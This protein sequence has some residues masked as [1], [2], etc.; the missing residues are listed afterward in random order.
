MRKSAFKSLQFGLKIAA[1]ATIFIA[2]EAAAP[3]PACP[4]DPVPTVSSWQIPTDVSIPN[5]F[6]ELATIYFDDY[7]WRA[8]IATVWP[9]AASIRGA[10]DAS[11]TPGD[12]GPRVFET[13]KS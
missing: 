13:W 6:S 4:N 11:K 10:A 2:A 5:G 12:A 3:G 9:A 7:S 1:R 8:F